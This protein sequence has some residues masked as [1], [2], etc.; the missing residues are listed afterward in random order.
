MLEAITGFFALWSVG[1][2]ILAFIASVIFIVG[3]E[4]DTI[5]LS[6]FATIVLSVIYWKSLVLVLTNPTLLAIGIVAWL[7]IGVLNSMW[8]LKNL[9]REVVEKYNKSGY[10]DPKNELSLS[11]QK[12]RITNWIIYWP[13]SLFWNFSRDFFNSLY[14]AMSGVYQGIID[15]ALSKAIPSPKN[16]ESPTTSHWNKQQRNIS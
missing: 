1:F 3:C 6:V 10:G 11:N 4:K 5:G 15:R 2:W 16:T 12:S 8:R 14:K 7:L 9:A 13:W